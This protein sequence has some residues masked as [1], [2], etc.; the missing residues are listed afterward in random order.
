MPSSLEVMDLLVLASFPCHVF[1]QAK[2]RASNQPFIV[3]CFKMAQNQVVLPLLKCQPHQR[4]TL[5]SRVMLDCKLLLF[6]AKFLQVSPEFPGFKRL[7]HSLRTYLRA[8]KS[9]CNL[10]RSF[11]L[12]FINQITF[13]SLKSF[14]NQIL[15]E[16]LGRLLLKDA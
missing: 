7:S 1:I 12:L 16:Q 8:V 14:P 10:L 11:A 5:Y 2:E 15:L 3:A 9:S 13:P 6:S 4:P